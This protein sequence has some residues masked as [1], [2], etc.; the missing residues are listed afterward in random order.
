MTQVDV[1]CRPCEFPGCSKHPHYAFEGDKARFC[2]SHKEPGMVDVKHKRCHKTGCRV[3]GKCGVSETYCSET[4][5]AVAVDVA[6]DVGFLGHT[7]GLRNSIP[8]HERYHCCGQ[9]ITSPKAMW[10]PLPLPPVPRACE[11]HDLVAELSIFQECVRRR[12]VLVCRVSLERPSTGER[13]MGWDG[14]AGDHN[15]R[16]KVVRPVQNVH[17]PC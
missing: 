17:A 5:I 7:I 9:C 8:M 6:V 12:Q 14:W 10:E 4:T 13:R 16:A 3:S 1:H 2:A 15:L 11:Q